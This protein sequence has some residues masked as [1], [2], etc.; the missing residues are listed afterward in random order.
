MRAKAIEGECDVRRKTLF[1]AAATAVLASAPALAQ[2]HPEY[3]PLGR[4]QAAMYKPDTGPAPHVAFL[5]AHRTANNLS[6]LACTELAKRGFLVVCFNTRFINNETIV[7]WE[8]TPLDVKAALEFAKRQPGITKVVLLGHSGGSPLMSLYQA[9]AENGV[10]FCQKPERMVKCSSEIGKLTPADGLVFPDA[11]PGN[12][13][14]AL[15]GINPSLKIVNG[16]VVVDSALDP[17]S[18]ANGYNPNGPSHYS[19]EFQTRYYAAQSKVM[20]EQLAK[21]LAAKE[22]MKK[23][24]YAFPDNDIVLVPFSDQ[25]G[26]AGLMLMDPS[27]PEFMSTARPEKLLK[28]DGSIV[29][30]VVHSV[31]VPELGQAK[32]NRR[33]DA[34]TKVLTFTSYLSANAT[35]STN[36]LDWIEH[37]STNISTICNLRS[38][39]API[40]VAAMGGWR[41]IRDQEI[42]YDQSPSTDKDYIVVEGAIHPYT[43]CKPCEK[44]PGQYS[45]T[46]KNLFDYIR[47]WT[48]KRF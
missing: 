32:A 27:I 8:E 23:D 45:N 17:F 37:C 1:L 2:S 13:A 25:D 20:N 41:F 39:K 42:M 43:P 31:A 11:H 6:T 33:F 36:S 22:A 29:T 7:N 4:V 3:V 38:I 26:S 35:R 28:N 9:I 47:D 10:E 19:K 5:V 21:V 18:E 24:E 16:K 44:T 12:P 14:Q 15:R 48:N 34:G 40:L 30:E 46:V